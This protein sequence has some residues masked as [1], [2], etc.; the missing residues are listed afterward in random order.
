MV[1][2]VDHAAGTRDWRK[3]SGLGRRMPVIATIAFV[4]AASMAGVPPLLGF[5]AKEAVFT[6]FLEAAA[7]GEPLG[8]DRAGR[9]VRSA[10]C[11]PSPTPC[12]SCGARSSREAGRRAD[13]RCTPAAGPSASRPACSPRRASSFAFAIAFIEPL[14]AAYADELPGPEEYHLALW[15]GLEPALWVSLAVFALGALLVWG[16]Q[17]VARL[18]AA[19]SPVVDS[20]RGYLGIVSVVDRLA[21][22]VTTAIQH[23]GLPGYLAII[24]AVFIG[25]LGAA[26]VMNT[27]WPDGIR[28]W[29]YPA[30]P[31][32]AFVMGVAAVAAA[33][34]RQ[35]MTAV[36]LVSVTGYGLVL[37]FGMSG[38][39]DLALT[40]AL[41]ETIVLV[42]F[43]L[44]LR[45]LPKQIAQRNPPVHKV[46]R[47]II[48][49]LAGIV[50][51]VIGLVALGARIQ[52]TIADGLPALAIEAHGKNIVNVM[53]VDIRAWDTLGEISVLVAVATGVASLIFV[54][55]RTGG[56]PRLGDLDDVDVPVDRRD[57]LRPV[58]EH[59]SSIRAPRTSLADT[60][61]EIGCRGRGRLHAA[62]VAPR[63]PHHLAAQPL[64]PHRGARAPALPPG[65]HRV[66]VPALRRAQRARAAASPAACSPASRSWRATSRAAATSSARPH[67]STPGACSA[68]A[69]CSPR[70]RRRP[71]CSSAARRSSRRGSRPTCRCSAP[72]RSAR[73]RSS[74]SAC[75]SSS[76]AS[77]STSCARS[78]ARSTGRRS[79]PAT[80]ARRAATSTRRRA[81]DA[82]EQGEGP[83]LAERPEH[84][85]AELE[86]PLTSRRPAAEEARR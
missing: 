35:R 83:E 70:A 9:R 39:P 11:S 5:V 72:S 38:A 81:A 47:G 78:A 26:S 85:D 6:A 77:C 16:R 13:A 52:P 60:E 69:C 43:V 24:V 15:H 30:Q 3:L 32:L 61:G 41:V 79:R 63:R 67:P 50:M 7:A 56:A 68:P 84:V 1:G 25:G 17:R 12:A 53:L 31:F 58:P 65:D 54:S 33:T 14:L 37:L 75:T 80:R 59:A 22:A 86:T 10:R 71:R 18:Q 73:R 46:A 29:D 45:R 27:T 51:G 21:A 34:V 36:L 49:A 8:V 76:S 23:R 57:R 2:I 4:A 82:I 28:L 64:D 19:V 44:V 48:G 66:G 42:V 40:Q 55:G 20:A 62:D 74:T